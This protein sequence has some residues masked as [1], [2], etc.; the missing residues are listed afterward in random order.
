MKRENCL[1][2]VQEPDFRIDHQWRLNVVNELELENDRCAGG[3]TN[4]RDSQEMFCSEEDGW[5]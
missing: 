4:I 2:G 1:L 5:K 3:V